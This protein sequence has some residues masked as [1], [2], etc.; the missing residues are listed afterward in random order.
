MDESVAEG[1]ETAR[2]GGRERKRATTTGENEIREREIGT[3]ID[4]KSVV[5]GTD[6]EG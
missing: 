3:G 5:R 4:R 6:R 2:A 1:G